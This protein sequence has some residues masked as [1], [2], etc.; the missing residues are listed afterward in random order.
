MKVTHEISKSI[1]ATLK[2]YVAVPEPDVVNLD[3]PLNMRKLAAELYMLPMLFDM[4]GCY[5]IRP[6][7]VIVSFAWDE[8]YSLNE[9]HDPRIQNTILFQ[10]A[11]KYPELE[12]L[13]PIRPTDA[14]ECSHCR[15]TGVIQG[16][17]E[18]G[19]SLENILCYC[20]GIGWL[21]HA[22]R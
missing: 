8:P 22:E 4:G 14:D 5:G 3:P 11:K 19:L 10:G 13:V 17:A 6:N 20:G 16:F 21:P 1:E 12:G 2:S 9:E 18:Q 15:G 7:G